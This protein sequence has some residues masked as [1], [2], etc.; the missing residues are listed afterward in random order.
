MPI[1]KLLRTIAPLALAI[2]IS[3][4]YPT[5]SLQA[6]NKADTDEAK[7]LFGANCKSCHGVDGSGTPI[8]KSV[9]APDLR[10]E[11]VQKQTDAQLA[12][13]ISGGKGNMPN[14]KNILTPDEIHSLV[15]YVR[16]LGRAKPSSQK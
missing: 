10:S 16:Q 7:T 12:E 1:V 15:R 14:F 5:G 13:V 8:G 11:E 9:N 2:A 3:S 6:A 4:I